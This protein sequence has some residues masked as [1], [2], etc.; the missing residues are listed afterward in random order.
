MLRPS[1]RFG[2]SLAALLLSSSFSAWALPLQPDPQAASLHALE[3]FHY[4]AEWLEDPVSATLNGVHNGDSRLP[5]LSDTAQKRR[6]SRLVQEQTALTNLDLSKA[7]QREQNDRDILLATLKGELLSLNEIQP[8]RHQPDYALSIITNGL[9]G[10]TCRDY[11]PASE[12]LKAA[13]SRLSLTPL[14]LQMASARLTQVPSIYV[15]IAKE[16]LEG[17]LSFFQNDLPQ[18][19]VDVKDPA[20]QQQ[21][22]QQLQNALEALK[23]YQSFVNHIHTEGSFALGRARMIQLLQA[24]MI[25]LSPEDILARGEAQREQDWKQF[26]QVAQQINPHHPENALAEIRKDHPST[27]EL[28]PTVQQQLG[29]VQYFIIT[30][31]IVTLPATT[32]PT[33]R[34]T[35]EF[36]QALISAATEWPGP[37]ETKK[38]PSFYDVTPPSPHLSAAQKELAL[39]D[40]NRPELLNIT[41]HE[42]LPGHF[43]QGLFL[44]SHPGWSLV[45]RGGGS[46]TTTE[47]WAHYSEQMMVE[48]GYDHASLALHLMQLQD[49]LLRDC[50]LL[51]SFGMHMKG[52]TLSEATE[53]MQDRCLQSSVAAYKEARRGTADP[54]YFS[55]TLGKMMILQLRHDLQKQQGS[56]FSLEQFHDA[57][58]GAGLVPMKVIRRELTGQDGS[59]L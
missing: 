52:M 31:H 54:G 32:L 26:W 34:I 12:R 53:L 17:A 59:L 4:T 8:D 10:L 49:A 36:E 15:E 3:Q 27:K 5:D 14:F 38:L 16:D 13:I 41:I 39:Q 1:L 42:A 56:H 40:F 21:F 46:Y 29:N 24:D 48:Q 11:A 18:A 30:H 33:V 25:D 37:F 57:L 28:I 22:H 47:G 9:Y 19:F 7:P 51:V 20:L 58:L 44:M 55:Y 45:R 2:Y 50:R 6:H 23:H 43:V 35:P